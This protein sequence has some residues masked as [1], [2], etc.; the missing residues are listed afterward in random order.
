M[1]A[2]ISKVQEKNRFERDVNNFFRRKPVFTAY[3]TDASK[4]PAYETWPVLRSMKGF[5]N[6]KDRFRF[7]G[8]GQC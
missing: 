2:S 4:H 3:L 5:L 8:D 1:F 7:E 6:F